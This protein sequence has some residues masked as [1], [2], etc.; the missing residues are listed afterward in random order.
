MALAIYIYCLE[1]KLF[2]H[3]ELK[4]V[5]DYIPIRGAIDE[6]EKQVARSTINNRRKA[7]GTYQ[8]LNEIHQQVNRWTDFEGRLKSDFSEFYT[9]DGKVNQVGQVNS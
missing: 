8:P 4:P 3:L 7:L 2:A 6:L 5:R 1:H 9:E